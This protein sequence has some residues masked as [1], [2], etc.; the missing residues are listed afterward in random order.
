M[1]VLIEHGAEVDARTKRR[2]T[3]LHYAA[4]YG[5]CF[6]KFWTFF[7]PWNNFIVA[8][9]DEIQILLSLIS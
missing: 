3:A 6:G 9:N 7:I 1:K 4:V 8:V 2:E 5:K